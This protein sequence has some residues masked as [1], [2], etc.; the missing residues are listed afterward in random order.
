V[1]SPLNGKPREFNSTPII[2]SFARSTPASND[3]RLTG[4]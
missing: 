2:A 4:L 3:V 1:F